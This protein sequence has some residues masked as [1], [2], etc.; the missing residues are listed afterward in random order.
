MKRRRKTITQ[1]E[2]RRLQRRVA[3]LETAEERRRS[4]WVTDYPDGV[5]IGTHDFPSSDS[6]VPTPTS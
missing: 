2:A 6:P 1:A 4:A 5:N 3:E